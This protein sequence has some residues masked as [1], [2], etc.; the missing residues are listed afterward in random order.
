MGI[1]KAIL[2]EKVNHAILWPTLKKLFVIEM[3]IMLDRKRLSSKYII[4]P[5]EMKILLKSTLIYCLITN[6]CQPSESRG[7]GSKRTFSSSKSQNSQNP[8]NLGKL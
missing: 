7:G 5:I 2:Y 8:Q 4:L 3:D 1:K 6:N